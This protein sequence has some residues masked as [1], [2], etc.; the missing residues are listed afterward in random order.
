MQVFTISERIFETPEFLFIYIYI[1]I[2]V[3]VCVC[4]C[5]AHLF[6][7]ALCLYRC[8]FKAIMKVTH[9]STSLSVIIL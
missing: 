7:P 6:V 2:Y 3:C 8:T 9:D 1:Y 5:F 4:L